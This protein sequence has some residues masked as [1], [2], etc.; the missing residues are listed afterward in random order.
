MTKED[1]QELSILK[2]IAEAKIWQMKQFDSSP[3][4]DSLC[5]DA[6]DTYD[7]II[8]IL[9]KYVKKNETEISL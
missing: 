4:M 2:K 7:K 5:K 1:K 8:K 3:M 9:K 6:I